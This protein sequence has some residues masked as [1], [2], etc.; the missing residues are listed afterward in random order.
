MWGRTL[1]TIVQWQPRNDDAARLL[2]GTNGLHHSHPLGN[3][4][5]AKLGHPKLVSWHMTAS[6]F[7][8]LLSPSTSIISRNLIG[9][10]LVTW[11]KA[12][13]IPLEEVHS[14]PREKK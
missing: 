7:L 2:V 13:L 4:A 12:G 11:E 6:S 14:T 9:Y 8:R 10:C 5:I 3:C 1:N